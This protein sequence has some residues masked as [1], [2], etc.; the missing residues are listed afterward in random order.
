[1]SPWSAACISL[2]PLWEYTCDDLQ[3][4]LLNWLGLFR[5]RR[6]TIQHIISMLSLL[7]IVEHNIWH[8]PSCRTK[9]NNNNYD[10]ALWNTALLLFPH[11]QMM[12]SFKQRLYLFS[13]LHV[14]VM[15]II[16]SNQHGTCPSINAKLFFS[17]LLQLTTHQHC[18]QLLSRRSFLG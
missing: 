16:L 11:E 14:F 9:Q 2:L 13:Y 1:M 7:K 6:R 17:C 5:L 4:F 12:T 8:W 18:I 3:W 10:A 15:G